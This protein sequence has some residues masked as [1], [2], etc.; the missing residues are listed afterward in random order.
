MVGRSFG[1][2]IGGGE[3]D[4]RVLL[5]RLDRDGREAARR[6]LAMSGMPTPVFAASTAGDSVLVSAA[7]RTVAQEQSLFPNSSA[8]PAPSGVTILVG[9]LSI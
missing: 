8:P 6:S 3:R 5:V 4:V 1:P 9:R 2:P 7:V